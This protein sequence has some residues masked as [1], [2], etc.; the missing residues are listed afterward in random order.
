VVRSAPESGAYQI[1]KHRLD[2]EWSGRIDLS[3][4][5]GNAVGNFVSFEELGKEIARPPL[6]QKDGYVPLPTTP[7][8]GIDRDDSALRA[9][10]YER[11]RAGGIRQYA[12]QP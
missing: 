1:G 9:H 5:T 10:G 8:L 12:D 4:V 2:I 3:S 7:V 6:L 11:V